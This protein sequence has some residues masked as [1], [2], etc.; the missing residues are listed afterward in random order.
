[1][2]RAQWSG[3]DKF[4]VMSDKHNGY[5][6]AD[7]PAY[8]DFK[9]VKTVIENIVKGQQPDSYYHDGDYINLGLTRNAITKIFDKLERGSWDYDIRT[10]ASKLRLR[11]LKSR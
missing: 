6:K 11:N 2:K 7:Y 3:F 4:V 8:L 10:L 9:V 5:V 1:M